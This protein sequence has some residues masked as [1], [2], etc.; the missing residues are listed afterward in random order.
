MFEGVSDESLREDFFEVDSR[1]FD[2]KRAVFGYGD[3]AGLF[4]DYDADCVGDLRHT[5]RCAVA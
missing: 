4:A 1:D 5:E 2:R 3:V